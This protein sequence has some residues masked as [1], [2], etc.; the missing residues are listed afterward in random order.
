MASQAIAHVVSAALLH[1]AWQGLFVAFLLWVALFVLKGRSANSRY[2]ASCVAMALLAVLPVITACILYDTPSAARMAQ[3]PA[4]VLEPVAIVVKAAA[5]PQVWLTGGQSWVIPVWSLGV[6]LFSIRLAW[7]C[8]LVRSLRRRGTPA[9][10][11]LLAVAARLGERLGLTRPVPVSII[12]TANG[13]SVVGWIRPVVLLPAATLLGLTPEQLEAILAH[14]LAHIRRHDYL[15]NLLQVLVET[16]LF[17]HPAVWWISAR[18]RHERELCC[19]DLAVGSC[20]DAL[21]YARA[22]V[23]LERLRLTAP[24]L[25]MAGVGGPLLYR[26][27]RLVGGAAQESGPSKLPGILA[28]ALGLACFAIDVHWARGQSQEQPKAGQ[29]SFLG[30]PHVMAE[31]D[32]R[33]VSIDLGGAAVLHRTSVEYPGSAWEKGIQGTVT[34]AVTLDAGGGVSD[35]YVI[36]GPTE[37]RRAV[38]QS[39]LEWHFLPEAAGSVRHVN[40]TFDA[41]AARTAKGENRPGT[42]IQLDRITISG[43][44]PPTLEVRGDQVLLSA[45]QLELERNEPQQGSEELVQRLLETQMKIVD[46]DKR[47]SRNP[48]AP[49]SLEETQAAFARKA[50]EA[51]QE[52]LRARIDDLPAQK[53]TG[54]GSGQ[55]GFLVADS[56]VGHKLARIEARGFSDEVRQALMSRIPVRIGDVLSEQSIEQTAAALQSLDEHRE[57]K[58][59]GAFVELEGGNFALRITAPSR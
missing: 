57:F 18:I 11:A 35:A 3:L 26:I 33:G 40:V 42:V 16:L 25:A 52:R 36:G 34:V 1:F 44:R 53:A 41:A 59:G 15:V 19:D 23:R 54:T 47:A 56:A 7:G 9:E 10:A 39:V 12:P 28:L 58:I 50:L 4:A 5:V 24:S 21:C 46:L 32:G 43:E 51:Q 38:L 31:E 37:L 30:L 48:P 8:G 20:G 6:L 29:F 49:G 55:A 22:L 14:E 2:V 17:Y 13:P 45:G 27:Q